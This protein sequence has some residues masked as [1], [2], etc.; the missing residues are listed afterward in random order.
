MTAAPADAAEPTPAAQNG[1]PAKREGRRIK[2]ILLVVG[3]AVSGL[4]II[5]STQPWFDVTLVADEPGAR[6]LSVSGD[7][8]AG[9]LAA[10]G[11]AG[12][13][14]VGALSIAGLVFR[15]VLGVLEGLIGATVAI[16]SVLA[17]S[18]PG[19]AAGPAISTAT[20]IAGRDSLAALVADAAATPWPF[21]ATILGVATVVIGVLIAV[22][23]RRWPGSPRKYRATGAQETAVVRDSVT[24]WDDLSDG[25]DPTAR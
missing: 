13:A 25:S 6:T 1:R 7:V 10:L 14:L 24:D 20:G 15:I 23:A 18:A 11:L 12:L 21:I 17:L 16:S 9:G 8:A 22:T 2:S 4:T 3:I 19:V 5:A